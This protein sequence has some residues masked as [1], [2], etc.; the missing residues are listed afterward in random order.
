MKKYFLVFAVLCTAT[1][2]I[3]G[4]EWWNSSSDIDTAKRLITQAETIV[5]GEPDFESAQEF[6]AGTSEYLATAETNGDMVVSTAIDIATGFFPSLAIFGG[7]WLRKSGQ[8]TSLIK[9]FAKSRTMT[10]QSTADKIMLDKEIFKTNNR[11]A[12]LQPIIRKIRDKI[13]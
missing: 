4:C 12:G 7:L 9:N 1:L 8:L 10:G 2:F 11:K 3:G 6:L 5:E 13:A